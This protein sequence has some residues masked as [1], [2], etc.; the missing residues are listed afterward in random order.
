MD[1]KEMAE[2]K[3]AFGML[4]TTMEEKYKEVYQEKRDCQAEGSWAYGRASAIVFSGFTVILTF[5]VVVTYELTCYGS[6]H[7]RES[8]F[9]TN[10]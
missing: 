7:L 1:E 6:I 9:F 8:L 10:P 3:D 2:L 4:K 5:F